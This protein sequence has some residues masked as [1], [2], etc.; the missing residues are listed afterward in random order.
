LRCR[1]G[2]SSA[3]EVRL[4]HAQDR[5]IQ[6]LLAHCFLSSATGPS[7]AFLRRDM[8]RK[9]SS[10]NDSTASARESARHE[11]GLMRDGGRIAL[12]A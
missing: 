1:P 10:D 4:Q 2:Q 12:P 9:A 7:V 6:V 5:R 3:V 8:S 11:R